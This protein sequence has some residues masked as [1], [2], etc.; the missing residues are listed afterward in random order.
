MNP[1]PATDSTPDP[2][3]RAFRFVRGPE[4]G[5]QEVANFRSSWRPLLTIAL[6]VLLL[7]GLLWTGQA[8]ERLAGTER[9]GSPGPW[10]P[11]SL[12]VVA[13]VALGG[14][15]RPFGGL[16]GFGALPLPWFAAAFGSPAAAAAAFAGSLSSV[17]WSSRLIGRDPS[18]PLERRGRSRVLLDAS[19]AGIATLAGATAWTALL[20]VQPVVAALFATLIWVALAHGLDGLQRNRR[21]ARAGDASRIPMPALWDG[22]GWI[23]AAAVAIV[24]DRVGAVQIAPLVCGF[25]L[26]TAV[27]AAREADRRRHLR[28]IRDLQHVGSVS[29]RITPED[30]VAKL[31]ASCLSEA[32]GA[33]DFQIFEIELRTED[34]TEIFHATTYG[35]LLDGAAEVAPHPPPAPGIHMR[36]E[37][38]TLSRRL[39]SSPSGRD[40]DVE[41]GHLR[42]WIDPRD[43]GEHDDDLFADLCSQIAAQIDRARLDRE[44]RIDRLTGLT[45]RHVFD[46]ELERRFTLA[47]REGHAVA[48]LLFD[49][50]HFKQ[51]ND[52]HG[53]EA[54][55]R[56]LEATGAVLRRAADPGGLACRWGGEELALLLWAGGTNA[57]VFAEELRRFIADQAVPTRDGSLSV[58]TSVG[59]SAFPDLLVREPQDLVECADQALYAA[60]ENGRNRA[61][62]ACGRGRFKSPS[63]EFV[64]DDEP[65][66]SE[67]IPRL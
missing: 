18:R 65:L 46:R 26:L 21:R 37:W 8:P 54:G 58:T 62:L 52:G 22:A 24:A 4:R 53:H 20:Q 43:A 63:G 15:Y 39:A 3:D 13:V 7:V 12:A 55:D 19:H 56:V 5:R 30:G 32:R 47:Q 64:G 44:A 9:S 34:G 25:L 27:G 49:L 41:L 35:P 48:L 57:L 59:V 40:H 50:D 51:V 1:A 67:Q 6:F 29:Q 33:L 42:L 16:L 2:G 66:P 14:G 10:I 38:K 28:R 23:L 60:K 11:I 31:A 45:R 61:L 17:W 36:R